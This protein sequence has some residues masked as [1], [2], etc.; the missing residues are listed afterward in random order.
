[1]KDIRDCYGSPGNVPEVLEDC[2]QFWNT[3]TCTL[4]NCDEDFTAFGDP[5]T[6][7]ALV[8]DEATGT[9]GHDRVWDLDQQGE[10]TLTLWRSEINTD[11]DIDETAP[12]DMDCDPLGPAWTNGLPCP[13]NARLTTPPGTDYTL[14][15][16]P[17]YSYVSVVLATES[18]LSS[19]DGSAFVA[20]GP[21][22]V[23]R[24]LAW[25]EEFDYSGDDFTYNHVAL[26]AVVDL[27]VSS[28]AFT[29]PTNQDFELAFQ[30][31]RELDE[32]SVVF[33]PTVSSGG[34]LDIPN[35]EWYYD[36]TQSG[37]GISVE[38]HLEG[39]LTAE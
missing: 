32:Y 35:E 26:S 11:C 39:G 20:S 8:E 30:G 28:R 5:P 31:Y 17:D 34:A 4:E 9:C 27:S 37:S 21:A 23:L 18:V 1:M 24:A 12:F 36:Y 6:V 16:D 10:S 22:R 38:V 33:E 13:E 15:I 3:S 14:E 7:N 19:L 29:V 2:I 25:G